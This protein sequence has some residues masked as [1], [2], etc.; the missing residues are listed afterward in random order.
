MAIQETKY[1]WMNG[2][3]VDWKEAQVHVL[4][5]ALHYG[6]GVFEGIRAYWRDGVV[7]VFRL[8]DHLRRFYNSAKTYFMEIPYS[9]DELSDAVVDLLKANAAREN[10][11]IRPIAYRAFKVIGLD[12]SKCPVHVA[13][14]AFPFGKY[15]DIDKGVHCCVSAWRRIAVDALPP[16]A[17][18]CGNYVNSA[19][20]KMEALRNGF[21]E[22]IFLDSHGYVCEGTGEN[23]F[24]ARA[25]I[26]Y[27]PP[28]SAAILEGITRDTVI[29]LAGDLGYRVQ[30]RIVTRNELYV[31]DEAFF[32]GTAAEITPITGVDHRPVGDGAIGPITRELQEAFFDVV[33]GKNERY[34]DWLTPISLL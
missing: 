3:L 24:I 1:I 10:C 15:L 26:L 29:Q 2:S 7:Y 22:A 18:A 11:Y 13:I 31:C 14:A 8:Q 32:T 34:K 28:T 16:D 27:T 20:A 5:H 33:T 12:P 17:K 25:N 30:E 21:D 6:T 4:T 19:L 9:R 23:I